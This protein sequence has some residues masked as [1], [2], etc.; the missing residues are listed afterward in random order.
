MNLIDGN[1]EDDIDDDLDP[2]WDDDDEWVCEFGERCLVPHFIHLRSE[3]YTVEMA[4]Q[5][6]RDFR[7]SVNG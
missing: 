3:C 1:W 4:E 5:W 6:E 7:E 2:D